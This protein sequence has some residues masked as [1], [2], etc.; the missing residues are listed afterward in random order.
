[1]LALAFW[2]AVLVAAVWTAD[3]GASRLSAPLRAVRHRFGL[4]AAGGSAVVGLALATPEI[5]INVSSVVRGVAD[6]GLGLI[7]GANVLSLPLLTTIAYVASRTGLEHEGR[8]GDHDDRASHERH[9]EDH[10]LFVEW[11]QVRRVVVPYLGIVGLL[12]ALSVPAGWR[13]IQAVD[14]AVMVAAYAVF[15]SWTTLRDRDRG[16]AIDWDTTELALAA[17]G[18]V[19]IVVAAY[20]IVLAT[21]RLVAILGIPVLVGGLFVTAPVG[22][23]PEAF[24]T[25]SVTRSGQVTAGTADVVTDSAVTMTLAVVPL[26]LVGVP[27]E[28][29]RLFWVSLLFVFLAPAVYAG[30]ILR[31][32]HGERGFTRGE[33]ILFD[34]VVAAYVAIVALW[35]IP[36]G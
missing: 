5:A 10:R 23:A 32:S 26:A 17:A 22:L 27:V 24:G 21:E 1:M 15:L 33:I 6:V 34:G 4:S 25:W 14:G 12:S 18:L 3:W 31:C 16:R 8:A 20:V 19:V 35:A 30:L 9:R 7:L 28:N 36:A 29:F 13:G 2:F 11:D